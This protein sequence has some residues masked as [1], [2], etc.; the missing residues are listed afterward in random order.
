MFSELGATMNKIIRIIA[1][2]M[3]ALGLVGVGASAAQAQSCDDAPSEGMQEGCES[4]FGDG[5][6]DGAEDDGTEDDGAD[7][8]LEDDGADD[9]TEDDGEGGGLSQLFGDDDE[10]DGTEDDGTVDDGSDDFGSD[11]GFG[12]DDG[13]SSD[14]SGTEV[15]GVQASQDTLPQTG[16]A[17]AVLPALALLGLGAGAL[18]IRKLIA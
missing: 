18:R 1:T 3:L 10:G 15:A 2:V 7:D 9:G 14:D 13:W 12:G 6:G 16:G 4:L 8:G 17:A 11:D 5:D